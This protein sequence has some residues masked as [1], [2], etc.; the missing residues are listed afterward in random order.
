MSGSTSASTSLSTSESTSLSLSASSSL[1]TSTSTSLSLSTSISLS[2]ADVLD[3]HTLPDTA[4]ASNQNLLP[5]TGEESN[6]ATGLGLLGM[7][8]AIGLLL[9]KRKKKEDKEG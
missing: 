3:N 8:G 2:E 6:S 1:S 9:A 4:Y 7:A 5:D